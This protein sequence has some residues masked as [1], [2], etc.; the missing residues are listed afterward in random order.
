MSERRIVI[1]GASGYGGGELLRLLASHPSRPQLRGVSR[2]NA[3]KPF[4]SVHPNL[5][6][7]LN[8][9]FDGAVDWEWLSQSAMP[10]LFSAMPH[11]ELAKQYSQLMRD[12]GAALAE[13]LVVIDLSADFR[14]QDVALSGKY[15]KGEHPSPAE[16]PSFVYGLPEWQRETLKSAKR[17]ANPGCFATGLQLA[18]LPLAGLD[19]KHIAIAGVTGSSGSGMAASE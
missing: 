3:G 2:H 8:G 15:Y 5:R 10:V 7:I 19:L 14:I 9:S 13:S 11:G 6:G 12:A 18:L 1:L 16:L 4:W 17:I